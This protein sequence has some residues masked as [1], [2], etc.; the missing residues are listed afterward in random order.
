MI[1]D[2]LKQAA[3]KILDSEDNQYYKVF[4]EREAFWQMELASSIDP[5]TVFY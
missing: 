2:I 3:E 4:I 1:F 5:P